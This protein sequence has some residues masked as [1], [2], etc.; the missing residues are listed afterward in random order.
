M[1]LTT[2]SKKAPN[3]IS[4]ILLYVEHDDACNSIWADLKLFK[5]LL[6]TVHEADA[7]ASALFM[8]LTANQEKTCTGENG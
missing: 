6:N 4:R 3:K 1:I 2:I 7:N 5:T 8:L